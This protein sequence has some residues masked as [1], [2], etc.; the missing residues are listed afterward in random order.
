MFNSTSRKTLVTL[1]TTIVL[2]SLTT[3]AH[4]D[5]T[6]NS[7][8]TL[9][10]GQT[11]QRQSAVKHAEP[12][13]VSRFRSVQGPNGKTATSE[14]ARDYD[15]STQ[16]LSRD[17]AVTG[18]NGQTATRNS[19]VTRTENGAM[20]DVVRT[21]P[22]GKTVTSHGEI[23]R[24]GNTVTGSRTVTGPD[25]ATVSRDGVASYDAATQTLTQTRTTTGPQGESSTKTTT[26]TVSQP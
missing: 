10:N 16:T 11:I 7:T 26:R 3:A 18:P 4:A 21:G 6:R 20:R 2:M 1:S 12:G 23:A 14:F 8:R 13:S 9:S 17:R 15:A 22:E 5:R 25:G 19:D 24:E